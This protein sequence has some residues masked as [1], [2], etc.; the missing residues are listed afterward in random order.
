MLLPHVMETGVAIAHAPGSDRYFAVQLFARP[1]SAAIEFEVT[2]R[3][4]ETIQYAV[5]TARGD[6]AESDWQTFELPPQG[7]MVHTRCL[8]PQIDWGWTEADD[9][10]KV[11]GKRTY[12]ITTSASGG[13]EATA[14]PVSDSNRK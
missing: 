9:A 5:G 3:T 4:A 2:N 12:V 8:P 14:Q 1:Q 11:A 10:M 13:F 6:H 7:T